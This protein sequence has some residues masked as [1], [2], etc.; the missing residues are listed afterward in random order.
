MQE[1]EILLSI[2]IPTINRSKYLKETLDSIVTQKSFLETNQVEIIISDNASTDETQFLCNDYVLKYKNKI[3]YHRNEENIFD[4]NFNKVLSLG[5]GKYLKLNN[6]TLVH[7]AGS[8]DSMLLNIKHNIIN[9]PILY[10]TNGLIRNQKIIT[11]N[12]LNSFIKTASFNTTWIGAFGIWREDYLNIPDFNRA[13]NLQLVQVDVLFRMISKGKKVF[14][15]NNVL[16]KSMLPAKKGGYNI[17]KIFVENYLNI[18]ENYYKDKFVNYSTLFNEKSKLMKHLIVPWYLN[19][20]S[21]KSNLG[22]VHEK[23]LTIIINKYK[24]HPFLLLGIIYFFIRLPFHYC[25]LYAK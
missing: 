7:Q 15:N 6:D 1:R 20:L 16:F 19:L 4:L 17:F 5:K 21:N 9:K 23:S 13:S 8:I 11:C 22:F 18:I 12:D 10:Y 2:C 14:I 25:K 3:I 24:Y